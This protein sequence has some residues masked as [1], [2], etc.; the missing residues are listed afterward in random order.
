MMGEAAGRTHILV[1]EVVN[2]PCGTNSNSTLDCFM[3]KE[4]I[5]VGL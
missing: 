3:K 4:F 5:H 1:F 2:N